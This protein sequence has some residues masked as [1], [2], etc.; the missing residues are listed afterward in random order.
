MVYIAMSLKRFLLVFN[1]QLEKDAG[2]LES[3]QLEEDPG[4]LENI[5]KA[6]G[7]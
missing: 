5:E 1:D 7:K 4:I 6:I 2:I 3:D